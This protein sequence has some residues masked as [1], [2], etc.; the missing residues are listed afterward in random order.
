MLARNTFLK[1]FETCDKKILNFEQALEW[2]TRK[3]DLSELL[4]VRKSSILTY[5]GI[6]DPYFEYL[7]Y[8]RDNQY[9]LPKNN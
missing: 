4:L 3:Q 8:I 6:G 7:G 1:L 2:V 9:I 5:A